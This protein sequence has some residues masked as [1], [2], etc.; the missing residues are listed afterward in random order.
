MTM[1]THSSSHQTTYIDICLVFLNKKEVRKY[2]NK[3][4]PNQTRKEQKQRY[5]KKDEI[6][7]MNNKQKNN[8]KG[9]I[10]GEK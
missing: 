8:E 2:K 1:K 10:K 5:R 3:T 7:V 6:N 4:K 9:M